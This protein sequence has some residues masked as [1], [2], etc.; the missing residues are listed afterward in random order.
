MGKHHQPSHRF[1]RKIN[2]SESAAGR[3]SRKTAA[4]VAIAG[5]LL[6]GGAQLGAAT[7]SAAPAAQ[8]AGFVHS[9]GS[10]S[11]VVQPVSGT[12]TSSYG[13]RGGTHHDGI[14]IGA[15]IGTPIYSAAAG[16]VISAG[17]A[18]GFGQWV[19]VQ[20]N[21]GTITVYGHVDTY[22]VSVGQSVTAGQQIATVG[23]RGQSTG[24]HLHFEVWDPSGRQVDP[25]VWLR[26]NG[27]HPTW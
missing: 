19:R 2:P 9:V 24:P 26:S 18:S 11:A 5:T 4:F 13:P 12:L 1:V 8:T 7:A 6:V 25:Q 3:R 21:D 15:S 20:H 14:D 22:L 10:S 27:V 23:N 16:S 17:P